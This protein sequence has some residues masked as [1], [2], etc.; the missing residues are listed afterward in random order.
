ML[1]MAIYIF[2]SGAILPTV[3]FLG[4]SNVTIHIMSSSSKYSLTLRWVEAF[5][6]LQDQDTM[7]FEKAAYVFAHTRLIL[8]VYFPL[9]SLSLACTL[10][11]VMIVIIPVFF[12]S[13]LL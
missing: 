12:F 13:H 5:T 1:E 4:G 7:V 10:H 9:Q 3:R 11:P 2:T 6:S 8:H